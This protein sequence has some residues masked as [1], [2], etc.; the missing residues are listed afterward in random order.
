MPVRDIPQ[1]IASASP[2]AANNISLALDDHCAL[3]KSIPV[4]SAAFSGSIIH[5]Y[6]VDNECSA[7]S[8]PSNTG[9][10]V[11]DPVEDMDMM[12]GISPAYG[13]LSEVTEDSSN[14]ERED[15]NYKGFCKWVWVI[16]WL[17]YPQAP[18]TQCFIRHT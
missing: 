5:K 13:T 2:P 18:T 11:T 16:V 17:F 3:S 14:R 8:D 10:V 12:T 1:M 9:S 7:S 4:D 6:P 15:A